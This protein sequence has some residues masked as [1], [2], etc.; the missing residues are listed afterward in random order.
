[1]NTQ[2]QKNAIKKIFSTLTLLISEYDKQKR[3]STS[4]NTT[5][6]S[7]L[8]CDMDKI[9]ADALNKASSSINFSD[10]ELWENESFNN[11]SITDEADISLTPVI[12][13]D[14][15]KKLEHLSTILDKHRS[16]NDVVHLGTE[17]EKDEANTIHRYFDSL[18]ID[19]VKENPTIGNKLNKYLKKNETASVPC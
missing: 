16:N 17:D 8:N 7:D 9:F 11:N 19:A 12:V 5:K 4:S 6:A 14:I 13:N 10:M 18:L 2:L 3:I 1:M 15:I